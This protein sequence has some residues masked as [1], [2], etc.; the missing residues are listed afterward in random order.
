M[1]TVILAYGPAKTTAAA[2]R[3]ARRLGGSGTP[4]VVAATLLAGHGSPDTPV[5]SQGLA[6]VLASLDGPTLLI[7]DDAVLHPVAVRTLAAEVATHGCVVVAGTNDVG[8]DHFVGPLPTADEKALAGR[9]SQGAG[10][11]L[12]KVIPTCVAGEPDDLAEL[13]AVK[14][15]DP[16]VTLTATKLRLV[17]SQVVAGHEGS[18]RSRL[19]PPR[20]LDGRPLLV[21]SM[22]V[23]DEEET[24]DGCLESLHGLVDRVDLCDT[25]SSDATL[26]IAARHG[27]VIRQVEWRDDFG[28]ARNQA[29]EMSRD[30][31]FVL[32]IDADERAVCP[33][34]DEFRRFLATFGHEY[35]GFQPRIFNYH[36]LDRLVPASE[37]RATRIFTTTDTVFAGAIHESPVL[38]SKGEVAIPFSP[39]E[40]VAIDHIG[41]AQHYVGTRNKADRNVRIAGADLESNESFRS[42]FHYARSL[43]LADPGDPA[44]AEAFERALGYEEEANLPA[45]AH[46][47]G[48]LA[49]FRVKQGLLDEALDLARRGL[50]LVGSDELCALAAAEAL[51]R[52]GRTGE[53]VELLEARRQGWS[54][55]P[56]FATE[57]NER[58]L[59]GFEIAALAR[60]GR[61]DEAYWL[62]TDLLASGGSLEQ[63][64]ALVDAAKAVPADPAEL[65]APLAVLDPNPGFDRVVAARLPPAD[66]TRFAVRY[67]EMGGSRPEVAA[68]GLLTA[69]VAEDDESAAV[70]AGRARALPDPTVR[71]LATMADDRGFVEVA[72]ILLAGAA[73]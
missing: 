65:L 59:T 66:C 62:A 33:D 29:L 71:K 15:I 38:M 40:M 8:S 60:T 53:I 27:A 50:E 57:H 72:E 68:T 28:W 47:Y 63:W 23:K 49:L 32:Q 10:A 6:D 48:S 54:Q 52:L 19:A 3:R 51:E 36:D 26:E 56:M 39:L 20:A 37:F 34:P 18:C 11:Q 22:I 41:Y 58:R 46:T 44:A 17:A 67:F 43:Q 7:H 25:G 45:R 9:R 61:F 1:N 42:L 64:P 35:Q 24:L 12:R 55:T 2:V 69:I 30:A 13:V 73:A 14:V 70:L 4:L 16:R 5:G 21:A 31:H